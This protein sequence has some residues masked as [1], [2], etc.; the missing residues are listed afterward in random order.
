[1]NSF[2][3]RKN[4]VTIKEIISPGGV[5]VGGKNGAEIIN[6]Y[7]CDIGSDLAKKIK[8]ADKTFDIN[9]APCKFIWESSINDLE[10]LSKCKKFFWYKGL[11]YKNIKRMSTQH[12]T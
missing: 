1:M 5:K 3:N 9:K 12:G 2:L 8:P 10:V 4:T 6:K 7:F 11:E